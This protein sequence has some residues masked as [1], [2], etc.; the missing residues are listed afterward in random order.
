LPILLVVVGVVASFL[1]GLGSVEVDPE[2]FLLLFIP[3]ILFADA[4]VCRVA[5]SCIRSS[6]CCCWRWAWS[7]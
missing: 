3:P 6:R 2:L 5:I 4:W 1:P 7:F